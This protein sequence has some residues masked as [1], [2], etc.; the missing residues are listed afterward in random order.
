MSILERHEYNDP[1]FVEAMRRYA[2]SRRN[3]ELLDEVCAR[4]DEHNEPPVRLRAPVHPDEAN[5]LGRKDDHDK[6]MMSLLP[7]RPLIDVARVMTFGAQKYGA[8][9]WMLVPD[10]KRR[11]IDAALRHI[12]AYLVGELTDEESELPTLAHAVCDLLFVMHF[13]EVD[14]A[15]SS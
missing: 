3:Q 8:D 4:K 15:T 5:G 10:A 9:N 11:Y 14:N 6:P 2:V 12:F 13:C 1:R 7:A